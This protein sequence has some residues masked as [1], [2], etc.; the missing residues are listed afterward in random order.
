[1]DNYIAHLDGLFSQMVSWR[2]LL[3]IKPELSF[4]EEKTA[5]FIHEQ[6][7]SWKIEHRT[8][9]GGHGVVGIVRGRY[10]GPTVALR[11]DIDALP[12]Q[13]EKDC[14]YASKVPGVM[15]ACGHDAH[16][17]ILLAIANTVKL[18]QDE[19]H[20]NFVFI[21]QPAEETTPGGALAM[22]KEDSL[23]GIDVIYGVHLWTPYPVGHVYSREGA[24]MA[25]PDEFVI[26]LK[27]KGGHGGLPH[28]AID[29]VLVG[30]HL[31]VNLQSIVS[32]MIDPTKSC[33]LS[34]G[35]IQ[36]GAAF[37]VISETCQLLG[38]VRTFDD[39]IRLE[40]K[41]HL[42]R[43]TS[44]TCAMF[45]ANY[46]LEYKWGYPAVVNHQSEVLRFHVVGEKLFGENYTHRAPQIMAGEDFSY[47]LEH[48]PGCF[49]FVGAGN[50][51]QGIH[52]PHHHPRF[53]IDETAMLHASKLL[54]AMS[55][56][57]MNKI[58]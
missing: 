26:K 40:M 35:S 56:N 54:I 38:T 10:N 29:T 14:E 21:F 22:I 20:G 43:I 28:Q 4:Q 41:K 36:G 39:E 51:S 13:D 55:L 24:M 58:N 9:V 17:A 11:A 34:I 18:M 47:Y 2:R 5:F 57:Y 19:I 42:E 23:L 6:L 37:N 30:S 15:H 12:I 31:V 53:D 32:R 44:Q 7:T 52:F 49:M 50:E 25:S 1:M 33:V 8:Q 48:V 46:E 16:T 45:Q 3:H 27:G